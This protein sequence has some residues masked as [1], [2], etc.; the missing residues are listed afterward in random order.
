MN[1]LFSVQLVNIAN[2]QPF[3]RTTVAATSDDAVNDSKHS[4][5]RATKTTYDDWKVVDVRE[6]PYI[7]D[8]ARYASNL[9]REQ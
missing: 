7:N 5:R 3:Q 4:A 2:G 6:V 8:E 9:R 1:P